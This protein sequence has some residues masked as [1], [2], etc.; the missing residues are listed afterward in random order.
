MRIFS[1]SSFLDYSFPNHPDTPDRLR[2]ILKVVEANPI[3][4]FDESVLEL[5]HKESYINSIKNADFV[6]LDTPISKTIFNIAL[7]A[8][9]CSITAALNNGFALVRPPGHHAGRIFG[10]GFCYFNNIAVAVRY[11]RKRTLILDL[12]AHH[13]NG[14]Q[15]IFFGDGSVHYLS[16]HQFPA[17]PYTGLNSEANCHNYPLPPGT[18]GND[19]ITVLKEALKKVDFDYEMIA[20]SMGFDT[21][22]KESLVNFN[23]RKDDY[24][25]IG[26]I[27]GSLNKPLFCVL[28][29]GYCVEDL[30]ILFQSFIKGINNG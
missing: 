25:K 2:S 4:E 11:L 26:R 23:L 9:Y 28:E 20:V 24:F 1:D 5:V 12:D 15:D 27:L 21:Y 8:V 13:G 7:R 22:Y 17:Y 18:N 19:Y 30:G 3:Q 10:G 6:S 29:G 14:T 16:I